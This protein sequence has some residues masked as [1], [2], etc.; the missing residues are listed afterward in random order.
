[1]T[2]PSAWIFWTTACRASSLTDVTLKSFPRPS[3]LCPFRG[4]VPSPFALSPALCPLPFP[5]PCAL[6]LCPIPRPSALCPT[7]SALM[8]PDVRRIL[9]QRE[10]ALAAGHGPQVV[11]RVAGR[12]R[13]GVIAVG[14]EHRVAVADGVRRALAV[15]GVEHLL[16]E[17]L[18]RRDAVVVDLL[19][20]RLAVAAVVLVRR[21]AAP[22][23]WRIERFTDHQPLRVR[24]GDEQVVDFPRVVTAAAR[25]HLDGIRADR[26]RMPAGRSRRRKEDRLE[27]RFRGDGQVHARRHVDGAGALVEH[28]RAL[29]LPRPFRRGKRA[30][31]L[32]QYQHGLFSR[33]VVLVGGPRRQAEARAR[34][35]L[36]AAIAAALQVLQPVD[37]PDTVERIV[38]HEAVGPAYYWFDAIAT[39]R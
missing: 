2:T 34:E 22:V 14:Q 27:R 39:V 30:A 26:R 5:R 12:R 18:R 16:A 3:A 9:V 33:D 23:A 31:P 24:I 35:F 32:L 29:E 1:A 20:H 17:A 19:K 10:A 38:Q 8:D 36:G 37:A 13:D 4:P 7:A 28:V 6:S 15:R 11:E 25:I 21:I